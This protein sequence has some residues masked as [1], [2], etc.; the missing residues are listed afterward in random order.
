MKSSPNV[1][2]LY[3]TDILCV[4]AYLAQIRIDEL[5]STFGKKIEVKEHFVSIFGSVESKMEQNWRS[6]GGIGAYAQHVQSIAHQFGHISI[7]PDI[8]IKNAPLTSASCHVFLKAI[9]ILEARNELPLTCKPNSTEKCTSELITWELRKAFFEDLIDISSYKNQLE[10]AEKLELPLKQIQ[11]VIENG[12]AFAA[13]AE[14]RILQNKYNVT[15]SPSLVLNEGRQI[16]YGNVGYRVIE[17]NIQELIN[18]PDN[19][20]SWC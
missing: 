5:Q 19:Q 20:A 8:W 2:I 10:V 15:G 12:E 3:F 11:E 4:W 14:D 1:T 7:H 16:I 17:A 6:R 18:Q 13:L 9:Q